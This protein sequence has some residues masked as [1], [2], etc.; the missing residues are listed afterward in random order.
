MRNGQSYGW[1]C[2]VDPHSRMPSPSC[3]GMTFCINAESCF[4]YVKKICQMDGWCTLDYYPPLHGGRTI[5]PCLHTAQGYVLWVLTYSGYNKILLTL[6]FITEGL[7]HGRP[8]GTHQSCDQQLPSRKNVW[9]QYFSYVP[10]HTNACV[11]VPRARQGR[12]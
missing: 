3:L 11:L 12:T 5:F 1:Y 10:L 2:W 9:V 6:Y 4:A 8:V 7:H